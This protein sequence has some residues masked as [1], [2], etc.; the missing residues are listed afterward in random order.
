MFVEYFNLKL[1]QKKFDR[2]KVYR[3]NDIE[4]YRIFMLIIIG[5]F[6]VIV[7]AYLF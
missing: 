3:E 5:T 1:Y 2:T 4:K 7:L 6:T